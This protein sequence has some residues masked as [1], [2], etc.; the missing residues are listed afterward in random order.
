VYYTMQVLMMKWTYLFLTWMKEECA[1]L[2][3][4]V[5]S[6][7][8]VAVGMGLFLLPPVPGVPI[9]L[10]GGLMIPAVATGIGQ[11]QKFNSLDYT[12][13]GN[14]GNNQ[15]AVE[16]AEGYEGS[17]MCP[18]RAFRNA[19]ENLDTW[20]DIDYND[21]IPQFGGGSVFLA[22]AYT[23]GVGVVLKLSACTLQQK[24]FGENLSGYVG[25]R[26]T[27]SVNSSMIRTMKFILAKPGLSITKVSR[28]GAGRE[29]SERTRAKRAQEKEFLGARERRNCW[30]ASEGVCWLGCWLGV[31]WRARPR[32]PP[33]PPAPGRARPSWAGPGPGLRGGGGGRCRPGSM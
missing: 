5:V 33:P 24:M 16:F 28:R 8:I 26:Q 13:D 31:C 22:V 30:R 2:D 17:T 6:A 19:T 27:V 7:I 15:G 3:F 10:T 20:A 11:C 1:K 25:V 23:V 29:R 18:T 32:P 21:T 14:G 4:F 12:A 9:Y